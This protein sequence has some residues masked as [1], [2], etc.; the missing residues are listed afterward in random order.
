M[1]LNE[2]QIID[3]IKNIFR[4]ILASGA[5]NL[6]DDGAELPVCLPGYTRVVS[7]DAFQ[8][9]NDFKI[10]LGPLESAGHRAIVQNLSD[11][12]AMGAKPVGFLWSLEIP[13]LWLQN[14]AL[15]LTKFCQGAL[16]IA[17][18]NHL[19]FYG[20]DLSAS[21]G[22][23]SCAITIFGDVLGRPLGRQG[24]KVG[25]KIYLSRELGAS[26]AGLA[27]LTLNG[28]LYPQA[29]LQLGQNLIGIATACMDISDG[30]AKDLARLCK[31]SGVGAQI[32]TVPVHKEATREQALYGGEDYA[33][34]FTAQNS[35]FGIE[36]GEIT[37]AP[38]IL[39][40]N[41]EGYEI[42]QSGGFDH[43][44]SFSANQAPR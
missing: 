21:H 24:A 25:D 18:E 39:I 36:I 40:K 6:L 42:L 41:Q 9:H 20:G 43:F 5:K 23:F 35:K 2:S 33:L 22:G 44:S 31:A 10:G 29:E 30:L 32:H 27:N 14:K 26:A 1:N 15:Y 3:L 38:E 16:Q 37:K 7:L 13:V 11:L 28:H 34:L 19:E 12:A 17:K 8:E 4:P